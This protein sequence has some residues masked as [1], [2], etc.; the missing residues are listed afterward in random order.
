MNWTM[1][2]APAVPAAGPAGDPDG[3]LRRAYEGVGEAWETGPGPA[4]ERL[5]AVA[6][7]ALGPLDGALVLDVGAGTGV[8][9]RCVARAG[10]TPVALDPA[11]DMLRRAVVGRRPAISSGAPAAGRMTGGGELGRGPEAGALALAAGG[12]AEQL[13]FRGRVFD[14]VV[15]A[16]S[17]SHV[18][19]PV[20]AL[21]EARR[22]LRP[23]GRLVSLTF[24]RDAP[25]PAKER[26][27][28]V[29][30][31]FGFRP[32]VWYRLAKGYEEA[33]AEPRRLAALAAAAGLVDVRV[34]EVRVDTGVDSA[35]DQVRWRLGKAHLAP[36]VAALPAPVYAELVRA[37][38]AA[39]GPRPQPWRPAVLILSSRAP[40]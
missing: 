14:A 23:G 11:L 30:A 21:R 15:A 28:A 16:F 39:L 19:E 6:V 8:A 32:P 36:F 38:Q 1:P 5:A 18:A 12:V 20:R 22:V 3:A 9:G 26:V 34:D 37:A 7:A 40:A 35:A 4:Y 33:T 24:G 10:G 31:G 29:A 17:L 13:P 2:T 27:D 25:H